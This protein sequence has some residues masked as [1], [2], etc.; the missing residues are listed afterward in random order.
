[1]L[2]VTGSAF[3]LRTLAG[4]LHFGMGIGEGD[5]PSHPSQQALHSD[6]V[7]GS[8][9]YRPLDAG[10]PYV[11]EDGSLLVQVTC[12]PGEAL[13]DWREYGL[14]A[15][16]EPITPG[17]TLGLAGRGAVLLSRRVPA[18]PFHGKPE[19]GSARTRVLRV[20]LRLH[21]PD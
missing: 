18:A 21:A 15:A 2:T 3:L 1:M 19:P 7:P 5:H 16:E 20:P 4:A 10:F 11:Q 9:W 8:A 14:I 17:H 13:F 6:G 12:D